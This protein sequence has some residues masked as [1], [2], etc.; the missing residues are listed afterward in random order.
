MTNKIIAS[1]VIALLFASL[2]QATA[3]T[4]GQ[5]NLKY[6]PSSIDKFWYN[7]LVGA[8]LLDSMIKKLNE[9]LIL[10]YNVTVTTDDCSVSN[11]FYVK[12]Q[13]TVLICYDLMNTIWQTLNTGYTGTAENANEITLNTIKFVTYHEI[14]HALIDVYNLSVLGKEEDAADIFATIS[15]IQNTDTEAIISA[16]VWSAITS[17]E[18]TVV[19]FADT[20][21]LNQQ[22]FFNMLCLL[23]GS[24]PSKYAA[25]VTDNLLPAYRAV[26]CKDEYNKAKE[27]WNNQ[28]G[29]HFKVKAQPPSP[30]PP[31]PQV[32]E[33]ISLSHF[34]LVDQL[35]SA[36]GSISVGQQAVLQSSMSND[37]NTDQKFSYIMQIKDSNGATIQIA[38]INGE[39]PSGKTFDIGLSWIPDTKGNYAVDVFVWQSIANPVA[40]SSKP[41]STTITVT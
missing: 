33:K 18:P 13:H 23:Y 21:S 37:L 17:R 32:G 20:H 2:T 41:L 38:W 9:K 35:G 26:S 3:E 7:K 4:Q 14:A 22:R 29:Q 28:L 11:A 19:A 40:L 12:E 36:L 25:L 10:P 8:R 31:S 1:G 5:F 24:D 39:I 30:Q 34:Q 6:V 15:S 27:S 16:A